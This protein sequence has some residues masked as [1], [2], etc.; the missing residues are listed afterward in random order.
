M[1]ATPLLSETWARL[2]QVKARASMRHRVTLQT[3]VT[4]TDPITHEVESTW[5]DGTEQ[6]GLLMMGLSKLTEVAAARGM[7][8][9]GTLRL[10]LG[11]I[12]T[13]GQRARVT[14][15]VKGRSWERLVELTSS[16]DD[17]NRLF[18]LVTVVDVVLN[19]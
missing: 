13:A 12:A 7:K 19:R 8:A 16:A 3:Q 17:T 9:D 2:L 6:A 18:G 15:T 5:V 14:G 11:T 4:T 10:E 1:P